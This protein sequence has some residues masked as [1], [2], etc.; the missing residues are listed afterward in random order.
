MTVNI[1]NPEV[2]RLLDSVVR[3]T[4][5]SKTNAI[6]RALAERLN[7]L[8][9]VRVVSQDE[10]RLK[11]F[12]RDEIWANIPEHLLGTSLTKAE[13]EAILGLGDQGI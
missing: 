1:K 11:A 13:E 5:E 8:S 7:R 12:L 3:L 10:D 2:E 9:L 4:G 6:R